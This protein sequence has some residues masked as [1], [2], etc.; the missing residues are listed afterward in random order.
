[1]S[2]RI[3]YFN[4]AI[5]KAK[6][7]PWLDAE[8]LRREREADLRKL[9]EEG[10]VRLV[11]AQKTSSKEAVQE[12]A[13]QLQHEINATQ[14]KYVAE[15]QSRTKEVNLNLA[16]AAKSIAE[17]CGVDV[18]VDGVA[19][20]GGSDLIIQ[21]GVDLTAAM[22]SL[23][24]SGTAAATSGKTARPITARLSYFDLRSLKSAEPSISESETL[25]VQAEQQLRK[26]VE[27]A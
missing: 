12:I 15:V 14:A 2:I 3:G 8:N 9:V 11:N 21:D 26:D 22:D 19:V 7:K 20:Y 6:Y 4:L 23:L 13:K 5:V 17:K 24:V 10:N 25:R 27:E 16:N 18:V 1:M